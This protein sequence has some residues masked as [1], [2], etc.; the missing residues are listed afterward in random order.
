MD[1]TQDSD[2]WGV[3]SI[4]AGCIHLV[5]MEEYMKDILDKIKP[6]VEK[7][8]QKVKELGEKI[9]PLLAKVKP[10][11]GKV[12]EFI[13]VQKR[14]LGTAGLFVVFVCVL[15]F[16]T[17]EDFNA[18]R[19]AKLNSIEVSGEDYVP[20]KEFEIDA[21]PEVNELIEKYFVA[22]V[23][24]DVD[25]LDKLVTPLSDMEKSYITAMSQFYEEYQNVTCYTKH[26][27]SK[28]SYIVSACFEIKFA[29]QE[30]TAPSMVL[31]YVQ[32]NEDGA[33][34]INNLYSDFNMKYAELAINKDVYTALKKYTTQEDYLELFNLVETEFNQLIRENNE[35]YQLTKRII[36]A[37]RQTWEDTVYYVQS[38]E[39]EESTE[40]TEST[41]ETQSTI[42]NPSESTTPAPSETP[43]PQPSET[44]QP[45][46]SETPQ[47]QPSETPQ[48]QPS[49]STTPEPEPEPVVHKVKVDANNSVNVRKG[50]GKSYDSIGK[51][52][53]GKVFVKLGEETGSDGKKWIKIQYTSSKVGY[54]RADYLDDVTE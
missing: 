22:Y 2:S 45:Q 26:G 15:V 3:G 36:P 16:F 42:P 50:P 18:K 44:P 19:I 46:P 53:D 35:I 30:T 24:A 27:L 20:E 43:Q 40:G 13:K 17:G 38:T 47:P 25:T 52:E 6:I 39:D 31:F 11:L 29:E 8:G 9:K 51:A 7:L 21:Y 48:P 34:Y 54:I 12:W 14:Y 5:F 41:Q 33:L 49:E 37:T 10:F 23:N 32:T 4:P 28:D 1:R